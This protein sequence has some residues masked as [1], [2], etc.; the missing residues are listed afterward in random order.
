MNTKEYKES[1]FGFYARQSERSDCGAPILFACLAGL[2]F[3]LCACTTQRITESGVERHRMAV[4][5]QRMDSMLHATSTW[6]Q[7]IFEK[8]TALVDSFRHTEVRDTSR[9][10]FLGEKGDTIREKTVIYVERNTQ[11]SSKEST[12]EYY[13]ERWRQTDSLLQVSIARQE[14]TDSLL[15]D[16][17]KTTVVEKQT[18]W[19]ERLFN[20]IRNIFAWLAVIGIVV[21]IYKYK[22][23]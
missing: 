15:R 9:T 22:K 11:Q 1:I 13:E 6:Q 4:M 2:L 17:Q 16:Y 5:A 20:H 19:H 12:S 8:Q 10:Y 23:K 14:R 21:A 7:T 3:L 18:P